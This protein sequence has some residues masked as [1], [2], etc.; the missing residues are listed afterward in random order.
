MS[1]KKILLLRLKLYSDYDVHNKKNLCARTDLLLH[2]LKIFSIYLINST[3]LLVALFFCAS[4]HDITPVSLQLK[5][6]HAFQFAGYYAAKEKGFYR[7]AGLEVEIREGAPGINVVSQVVKGDVTFGIASSHLIIDRAAG[8]PVVALAVIM[9]HS[10]LVL[11][12][13]KNQPIQ[14]VQDLRGKR[15]MIELAHGDEILAYLKKEGITE[16]DFIRVDPSFNIQDLA[17][18]KVDAM[19]AYSSNGLQ[20]MNRL[21]IPYQLYSAR[22][23]GIDFYND[24]LFTSESE[25]QKHPEQVKAFR[26]ASIKGWQ[27]ALAHPAE[28]ADLIKTQYKGSYSQEHYLQEAKLFH[29]LMQPNIIEIGYSNPERWQSIAQTYVDL[30][31]MPQEFTLKGFIY[32]PNPTINLKP[33]YTSIAGALFAMLLAGGLALF[34]SRNNRRLSESLKQLNEAHEQISH[35]A[36]H[37]PLTNLPNRTLLLV[38]FQAALALAKRNSN[39]MAI[40]FLDLDLFKDINDCHGHA[41]GDEILRQVAKRI[42][43]S[44]RESDTAGRI[45]GDEFIILLFDV[46]NIAT[47]LAIAEKIRTDLIRPYLIDKKEIVLGCSIGISIYPEDGVEDIELFRK[48]DIA[49]YQAK[50]A[51]KNSSV[52]FTE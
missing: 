38:R 18:G 27:Y 16:K 43:G 33:F 26:E 52:L 12:A 36:N 44:I 14:T 9:Q 3:Y 23:A 40:L 15:I 28:I 2:I 5:W 22:E 6:R 35:M 20:L 37:D 10:P 25:I 51:G 46:G 1:R 11:I 32:N 50:N 31:H 41:T 21:N 45:G 48:A 19:T 34:V 29:S 49:L 42:G 47:A 8:K 7:E 24:V 39:K 4:A 13:R 30:G 17:T